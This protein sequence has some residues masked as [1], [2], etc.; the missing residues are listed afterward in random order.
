MGTTAVSS[1]TTDTALSSTM[2]SWLRGGVVAES[3]HHSEQ[4]IQKKHVDDD[5]AV[6]DSSSD[7]SSGG[8]SEHGEAQ[9]SVLDEELRVR[10]VVALRVV[11]ECGHSA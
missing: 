2:A 7:S 6:D 5:A 1:A 3:A 11:G 4:S 9:S 8:D 10:G